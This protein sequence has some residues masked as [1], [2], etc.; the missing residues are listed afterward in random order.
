MQSACTVS[1]SIRA[2]ELDI[3]RVRGECLNRW[4]QSSGKPCTH[5]A[6]LYLRYGCIIKV[7]IIEQN[8]TI[9]TG[10]FY[11]CTEFE[12]IW[13]LLSEDAAVLNPMGYRTL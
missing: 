4:R 10:P 7:K 12:P 8:I 9:A 5:F 3:H 2:S 6:Q 13:T 11:V 1:R